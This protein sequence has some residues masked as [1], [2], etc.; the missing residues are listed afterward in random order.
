M[1]NIVLA[2]VKGKRLLVILKDEKS[3]SD[4]IREYFA[5][6]N[7]E[8]KDTDFESVHYFDKEICKLIMKRYEARGIEH[9]EILDE[10]LLGSSTGQL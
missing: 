3:L 10:G 7:I 4:R 2:Q 5:T 8:V 9:S 6:S 1:D